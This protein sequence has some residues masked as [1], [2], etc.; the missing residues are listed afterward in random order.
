MGKT[1]V[2]TAPAC[3]KS[4]DADGHTGYGLTKKGAM[5]ALAI[6]KTEHRELVLVQR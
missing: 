6:A 2:E 1:S 5:E 4:S 3:F